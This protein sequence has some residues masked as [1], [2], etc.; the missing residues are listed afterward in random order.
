MGRPK[1]PKKDKWEDLP[2]GFQETIDS[3]SPEDIKKKVSQLALLDVTQRALLKEDPEVN[4]TK[5]KL[6]YLME[7]YREDLKSIKLQI[8]YAK[9][10][11]EGKGAL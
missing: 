7:P 2:E 6:K 1:G 8:A 11:L 3:S 10:V 9:E 5:D 4:E